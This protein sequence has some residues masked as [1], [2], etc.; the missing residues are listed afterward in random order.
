ML[1]E[2]EKQ[3]QDGNITSY[4]AALSLLDKYFKKHTEF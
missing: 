2:I 1:P 4:K 3:L